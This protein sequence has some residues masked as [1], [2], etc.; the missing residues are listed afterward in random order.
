MDTI[1]VDLAVAGLLVTAIT[2][3]SAA[4]VWLGSQL[5]GW[6]KRAVEANLKRLEANLAQNTALTTEARDLSNGKL[7]ATLNEV[8]KYR[9]SYE[10]YAR[11]VRELNKIEAARPYLD[12]A[13]QAMRAVEFDT[14]WN[15]LQAKL[16]GKDTDDGHA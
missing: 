6:I 9:S 2:A 16:L 14:N 4:I 12:Q 15:A 5:P 7:S 11:L 13:A 8:Q 1:T 10:R 3:L